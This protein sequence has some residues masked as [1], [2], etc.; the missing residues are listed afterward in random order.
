MGYKK[1]ANNEKHQLNATEEIIS[2]QRKVNFTIQK[3]LRHIEMRQ[4]LNRG[5]PLTAWA[6]LDAVRKGAKPAIFRGEMRFLAM[7]SMISPVGYA[8]AD[9]SKKP[10]AFHSLTEGN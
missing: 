7:K 5:A 8:S 2:I 9:K 10:A 1:I 4:C 3:A 6:N